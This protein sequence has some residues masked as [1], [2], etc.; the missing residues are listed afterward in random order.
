MSV[1]KQVASV[2]MCLT[3]LAVLTQFVL[4]LLNRDV[5]LPESIVRFFSYFT[6][7]T[8]LLVA[9]YFTNI[10][11][12]KEGDWRTKLRSGGAATAITTCILIVGII[13]Q[14]ILKDLWQPT[15]LHLLVDQ[16][17]HGIIPLFM[18][19][20]WIATIKS[21]NLFLKSVYSWLLYP[22]GYL[23]FALGRGYLSGFYP[24]PFLD[25]TKIGVAQTA[26]N[27]GLIAL[28]TIMMLTLL[29]VIGKGI[30]KLER[31]AARHE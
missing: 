5:S 27:I 28:G 30:Q 9:L 15:G 13:Y 14:T 3:W 19:F 8:N 20:F 7:T 17:L 10:V 25:M 16:L 6:I 1:T 24:Y 22:I 11:F 18:L 4:M 23:L 26:I 29:T 31:T 2:G 21:Q 12:P